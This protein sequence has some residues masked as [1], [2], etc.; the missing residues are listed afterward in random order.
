M[1]KSAESRKVR[2]RA[3][4]LIG[5]VPIKHVESETV[6]LKKSTSELKEAMNSISAIL[7]KHRRGEL[8]FGMKD[9]GIILGQQ[10]GKDTIRDISRAISSYIEPKIYPQIKTVT[11]EGKNC[12]HLLFEGEEVPYYAFGRAYMRVGDEDRKLSAKELE[13]LILEKNK[14]KN[15]WESEVSDAMIEDVNTGTLKNYIAKAN[16]AGRIN[17]KYQNIK[18]TLTKLELLQG[19]S[20]LNAGKVL[21]CNKNPFEIQAAVFAGKDKITFLDI[22]QLKGNTFNLLEQAE[23]YIKEHM[24]WRADLKDTG[25]EEIPEIPLRAITEALVNS[26][27]HRD[28]FNPKGNEIAV[29]KDRI[30][31]YNPGAFP[32]GYEPEDF[33]R[34][35]EKSILRNPLIANILFLSRDIERWGS[36]LQRIY[37]ACKEGNVKVEF[38][39]LKSGFNIVFYRKLIKAEKQS[40][41]GTIG[42]DKKSREKSREKSKEKILRLIGE[43]PAIT[44]EE[45]A[46]SIG[47]ST[48]GVEKNI[49]A[50]KQKKLLR[51]VGP[52]K[53]GH[54]EVIRHKS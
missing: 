52:D 1:N 44:T 42:T 27:C 35:T 15:R 7:N 26:L 6:E 53:G 43:N 17:F 39:K 41:T 13:N 4:G 36:G 24:D 37:T 40:G 14:G 19:N 20:L 30:E 38:Q 28:F 25:R 33:I 23:N 21:F 12:I 11:I 10:I 32:E 51:R 5:T 29:F 47:L 50:L 18:T 45:I 2:L 9:E 34:G 8:Y 3:E 54:W 16:K 46:Q 49:K 22:R 31:I 48:A